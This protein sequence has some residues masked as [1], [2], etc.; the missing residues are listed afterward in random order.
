MPTKDYEKMNAAVY[1]DGKRAGELREVSLE[2]S[3]GKK[4]SNNDLISREQTMRVVS[5][6]MADIRVSAQDFLTLI[7]L[8]L[9]RQGMKK[10]R[11]RT[12]PRKKAE[13]EAKSMK[14]SGKEAAK[15]FQQLANTNFKK[16]EMKISVSYDD[17][18]SKAETSLFIKDRNKLVDSK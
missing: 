12:R 16:D 1:I 15:R 9:Y 8:L 14:D 17:R 7:Q 6:I 13:R 2:C 11:Q 5:E 4:K 3:E 10:A 18:S